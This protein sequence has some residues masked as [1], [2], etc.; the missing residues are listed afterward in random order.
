MDGRSSRFFETLK[1]SHT[2][3]SYVECTSATNETVRLVTLGGEVTVDRTA[4]V[5]RRLTVSCTD[6][7]GDLTPERAGDLLTPY[8][9]TIRPY[10]GIRY[11]D[12]TIEVCALGVFRL[13]QVIITD[14][15]GTGS[16]AQGGGS[17]QSSTRQVGG[18]SGGLFIAIDAYDLSRTVARDKFTTPY[19][20]AEGTNV[21]S[22]IQTILARTFDDLQ[23]DAMG[24]NLT[25]TP[26]QVYDAGSDP[27]EACQNLA[28]S[29]GAD[30][31]FD[32]Y[33]N[34]VIS[35]PPDIQSLT[36]A[37]FEYVE[38]ESGTMLGLEK[39]FSDE[40]GYNGV[41]VIGES[42]GDDLP[43]VT[44][45]AWDDDPASLTYHLG[46]YGE[47][48]MFVQDQLVKTEQEAQA[49]ANA[50]LSAILGFVSQVS[51]DTIVNPAFEC[52]DVVRIVR[53]RS[54]VNDYYVIDSFSVPLSA[55]DSQT[56]VLRQTRRYK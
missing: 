26:T 28:L 51:L 6:P 25:V 55:I 10:R 42:P 4:S 14:D 53:A 23:Y 44:A 50:V 45:T 12:G 34:V 18:A 48:P 29:L 20:I 43:P 17:A 49:V 52:G 35:P 24:T 46:P 32:I 9:T 36:A 5:R 41:V 37:D 8:G 15:S 27:W 22:A 1:K 31:Y 56:L 39:Y 11:E 38:G 54:K 7:T 3:F 13:S 2:S 33:G 19:I 30:L 40:P 47:V 21:I 16:S